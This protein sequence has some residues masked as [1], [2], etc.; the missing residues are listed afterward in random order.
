M[1]YWLGSLPKLLVIIELSSQCTHN[2]TE[3]QTGSCDKIFWTFL[4]YCSIV[5]IWSLSDI[6]I[7]LGSMVYR[8]SV[9]R[10]FS[11]CLVSECFIICV[12]STANLQ[13][14]QVR[15]GGEAQFIF[16][17]NPHWGWWSR[18]GTNHGERQRRN[19]RTRSSSGTICP[20]V[21][22]TLPSQTPIYRTT[23]GFFVISANN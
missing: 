11:S 4:A 18:D 2:I 3:G 7:H 20:S 14:S 19:W 16:F 8:Q 17:R 12:N 5:C 1:D 9:I 21:T 22:E 13:R 10:F 6:L 15:K 23:Q